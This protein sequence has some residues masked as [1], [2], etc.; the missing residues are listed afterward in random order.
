M[1]SENPSFHAHHSPMGALAS[2]TCGAHNAGGGMGVE[3]TGP[4]QGDISVGYYEDDGSIHQFPFQQNDTSSEAERYTQEKALQDKG[5]NTISPITRN[6][7]WATDSFKS[8]EV[9]FHIKTP[10][11]PIPD[12][13]L[14]EPADLQFACCPAV[15]LTLTFRNSSSTPRTGFFALGI[16]HRWSSLA[17]QTDNALT[18]ATSRN[19]IGF[20]TRTPGASS[21]MDFSIESAIKRKHTTPNFLLGPTAGIEISVPAG[22]TV[23]LDLVLG[24]FLEGN[25]TYNREMCYYYTQHFSSLLQVLEY[26]LDHRDSYLEKAKQRDNELASL[27]LNDEQKFLI[28]HST[29][30]YYGST[31]WLWDGNTSVWVVNEGEY[32][33]MNT[34]DLTVDMLFFEMKFNPW[35]IRNV[36]NN[37]VEHYSFHDEVFDPQNPD[38]LLPGGISFTH[39]MGVMNHWSPK[40]NSSYEVSGLDRLCFSHMT[41]EQLTNWI[42]TAGI[43][44]S[45]TNDQEFLHHRQEILIECLRSLQNRDNPDPKKRNGIMNFESSRT[46]PG[47]EITT[48]DSLDHSLGQSRANIYLGGK[49]WA[50][51]LTLEKLFNELGL[52][53]LAKEAQHSAQ[54]AATTLTN[55]YDEILGFIPAVLGEE[56][57]SAIIPAI[58]ALVY[59]FE[60]GLL[61]AVSESG[62]Y[63][64]YIKTLK[65]HLSHI[66]NTDYCLYEDGGWKLS[67]SADNSWMSKICLCQYVA[68]AILGFDFGYKQLEADQA[69]ARWEREGSR[70][71]ACSDQF[72]SGVAMGSLYYPRIVT[73]ILWMKETGT[74]PS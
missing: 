41:C 37:F 51:H 71:Q 36:L 2:F 11:F 47:G 57:K 14:A 13:K 45:Q 22:Q 26:G 44:L 18:G 32:L 30:S 39:D 54:L 6:Y 33:M 3:L 12:P 19:T 9:D 29:R 5:I 68:R 55:G 63:G 53:E 66:M 4:Y 20:A 10:F 8:A 64:D 48:Y 15:H 56:T 16:D 65:K 38:T 27:P 59:P 58:E 21:F 17:Q 60:M 34:F 1:I 23:T 74:T 49:I 28:A 52:Q 69:H 35:T 50:S 43:Y 25:V 46:H 62:L 42:L 67:S 61:R 40:G 24:F 72:A 31:Q 70:L 73:S 7:G